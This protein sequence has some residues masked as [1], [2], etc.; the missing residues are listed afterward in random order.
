M[1]KLWKGLKMRGLEIQEL[2]CLKGQRGRGRGKGQSESSTPQEIRSTA[3]VYNLKTSE[4]RVDPEIITAKEKGIEE[5]PIVRVFPD[6]Y[7]AELPGLPPDRE[8]KFQI[9]IMPGTTPIVMAPYIMAR[10]EL[11]ELKIQLQELL[12]K[13]F[14]RPSF[15]PWG[16]PVLF[17]KK[18]N[19]SMRLYI[20]YRQLNKVTIK[21]KYPL[22]RIN[23][24]F[25]QL[26]GASQVKAEH[27]V[28]SGLLQPI[29]IPQWKSALSETMVANMIDEHGEWDWPKVYNI[30]SE[31]IIH[32][33]MALMTLPRVHVIDG[34]GWKWKSN[35]I[36]TM[37]LAYE[38]RIRNMF[39][40]IIFGIT[41]LILKGCQE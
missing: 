16:A 2:R 30:L 34:F 28:P 1:P 20:E 11:Q 36:F 32:R 21:N 19:G 7:P 15:S 8:V 40:Y 4:D 27:Q 5:I 6:V 29:S 35:R 26:K 9:E 17:V 38:L 33:L 23:D 39:Q 18:N 41:L 25:D 13:G 31:E 12:D 24:L 37:K 14:I 22:R 10:K 3:R